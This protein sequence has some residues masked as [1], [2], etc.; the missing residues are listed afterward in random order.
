MRIKSNFCGIFATVFMVVTA[1]T[2]ASCSQDDD[3]YNSN[4][5]TLAEE[6]DTRSGEG[7]GI[8]FPPIC[9]YPT[10][11]VIKENSN[12]QAAMEQAWSL[13][14]SS[15]SPSGRK[16]YGF[17]IYYHYDTGEITCGSLIEGPPISGGEGTQGM[18]SFLNENLTDEVCAF[19]HTHTPVKY[20]G[21]GTYRETGASPEDRNN[22][23]SLGIPGL[24]YDYIKNPISSKDDINSPG[25]VS[26]FGPI[27]RLPKTLSL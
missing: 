12:V 1:I 4:M 15:A 5:Y 11:D 25:E 21:Y 18:I 24:V 20:C 10:V 13:T 6:M 17:W 2:I 19:F 23:N 16:E 3:D 14:K 7:G 27:G 8:V 26:T 9:V 22:A